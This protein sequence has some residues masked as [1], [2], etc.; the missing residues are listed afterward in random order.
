M[1]RFGFIAILTLIAIGAL[2]IS[3]LKDKAWESYVAGRQ[4]SNAEH[5][6]VRKTTSGNVEGVMSA[7]SAYTWIGIPYAKPPLGQLRWR[8]PQPP[9]PWAGVRQTNQPTPPCFQFGK[10]QSPFPSDKTVSGSEDCLTL[11]I[12]APGKSTSAHNLPVIVWFH[13]GDNKSGGS[14][15][16]PSNALVPNHEVILVT[17]SHRL[18]GFGWFAHPALRETS[19]ATGNFGTLDMIAV[20]NWV[21]DNIRAFGGDPANVMLAG[22]GAGANN[23]LTLLAS[24]MAADLFHSVAIGNPDQSPIP[25]PQAEGFVGPTANSS[26]E[27][28]ARL[29]IFDGL[30]KDR[31]EAAIYIEGAAPDRLV[32]YLRSKS[33]AQFLEAYERPV[34]TQPYSIPTLF[35][36]GTVISL[37]EPETIFSDPDN[38]HDVPILLGSN[39]DIAKTEMMTD[40]AFIQTNKF[41][42]PIPRNELSYDRISHYIGEAERASGVEKLARSMVKGGHS[43]VYVYRF[44]W[45]EQPILLGTDFG[46]LQGAATGVEV[47]FILG[48]FTGIGP[49][50]K[51]FTA[52]NRKTREALSAKM[53][54][55][56]AGLAHNGLPGRGHSGLLKEWSAYQLANGRPKRMIFDAEARMSPQSSSARSIEEEIFSDT[57]LPTNEQKC[58]MVR[59]LNLRVKVWDEASIDELFDGAC[60]DTTL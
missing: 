1:K 2:W 23:I 49:T 3:P 26:N 24:P 9:Y 22:Q 4:A 35:R 39:R 30:V 18:G 21:Q 53:M 8:A 25:T 13:G 20:L 44:D 31:T 52:G 51:M 19:Q 47:P 6:F 38:Y 12:Q 11:N 56:W 59:F 29:L 40:R 46:F 34:D 60:A 55:Y 41:E 28:I 14:Q 45:D 27:V 54:S 17:F 43:A 48:Q 15:L 36:D 37:E 50:T 10:I 33:A 5:G 58:S 7:N 57:T 42:S 32:R 16:L